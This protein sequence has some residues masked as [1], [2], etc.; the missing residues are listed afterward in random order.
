MPIYEFRCEKCG[1]LTELMFTSS[2]DTQEIRCRHCG[3]EEM[4]R[5]LSTTHYAM[6]RAAN[7][8]TASATTKSCGSGSCGTLEIPGLGD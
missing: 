8:P 3:A 2:E 5:V 1:E 7:T 4:S 6:G